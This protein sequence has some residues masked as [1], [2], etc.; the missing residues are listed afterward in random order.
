LAYVK[1][2]ARYPKG[3]LNIAG[4]SV[5]VEKLY[6]TAPTTQCTKCLG[7]KTAPIVPLEVEAS[8]AAPEIRL[9]RQIRQYALRLTRL[10][11]NH[12]VNLEADRKARLA[13]SELANPR[14]ARAYL[15][16][17]DQTDPNPKLVV[18]LDRIK[19][20]ISQVSPRQLERIR[21]FYFAPWAKQTPYIVEI[22]RLN[23]EEA[24]LEHKNRLAIS[25]SLVTTNIYTD[26]SA[27]PDSIGIG[28]GIIATNKATT[29]STYKSPIS[30]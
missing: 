16:N 10:S 14:I 26:A 9:N 28:I 21:P 6:S 17:P 29:R 4:I 19:S 22:S 1:R 25:S 3:W 7:F 2:E 27:I 8:L 11:N 24:S 18:Q 30:S 5:R 20:S 13:S 15:A 23:K 12:L